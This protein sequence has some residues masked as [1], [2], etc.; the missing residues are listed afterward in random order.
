MKQSSTETRNN[1]GDTIR[2][3]LRGHVITVTQRDDDV[4]VLMSPEQYHQMREEINDLKL[5]VMEL[6][7]DEQNEQA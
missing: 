5:R 4:M 1:W 2:K 3:V 6:S 7:K